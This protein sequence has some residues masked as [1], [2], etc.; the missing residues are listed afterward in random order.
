MNR[1]VHAAQVAAVTVLAVGA[2]F[3]AHVAAGNDYLTV[4][5]GLAIAANLMPTRKT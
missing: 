3:A 4:A 2:A 5:V 1:M